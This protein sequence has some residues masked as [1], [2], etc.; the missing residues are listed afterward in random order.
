[1]K[2]II[3]PSRLKGY[4]TPP[5][6]KSHS[7]RAILF[8]TLAKGTSNIQGLLDSSDIE[9]TLNAAKQFGAKINGSTI[10]GISGK[11]ST[12]VNS[13]DSGNSGLVFRF[14]T[15]IAGLCEGKVTITGDHSIQTQRPIQALLE[16]MKPLGVQSNGIQPPIQIQGPW[17]GGHTC[18]STE[19]SQ[20]LSALLI[21][22]PFGESDTTISVPHVGEKP[23][24]ELTL[25]WLNR[26]GI[27]YERNG[28]YRFHIPGKQTLE[29]FFY[30]VPADFS[31][32]AFPLA[33][34]LLTNSRV[35]INH[36]NMQDSQGDKQLIP[37]LQELGA[38]F[39]LSENSLT[40]LPN[41]S[42]AGKTIDVNDFIDALPILAVIGTQAEGETR[43]VNA[44]IARK[45]ESNRIV[46]IKNELTKMGAKIEEL[47]D[48]LLIRK[49]PLSGAVV[50]A[51]QDH[52]IGMALTVAGLIA[53]GETIIEGVEC[54]AKTYKN[55]FH[56][57]QK[58]GAYLEVYE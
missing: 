57:L 52:R 6:S 38:Q 14:G 50:N 18:I 8:A 28:F 55:F 26:L 9:A 44:A 33:A 41:H 29:R 17:I 27:Q 36:L 51:H 32:L 43:I 13:I 53:S 2:C 10:T 1:M 3:R 49:S 5:T 56:D 30:S 25:D 45:K 16:A 48:G 20:Q 15:S 37:C 54:I 19:D 39:D 12:P 40:V 46:C 4:L 34:A 35:T 24:I 58:L 23:W 11:P 42:L 31:S 21:A 22:A 7:I 47:P